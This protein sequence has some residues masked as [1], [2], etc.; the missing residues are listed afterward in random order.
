MGDSQ[1]D[2]TIT[3]IVYSSYQNINPFSD[4]NN[5]TY[6]LYGEVVPGE[7]VTYQCTGTKI[8]PN[9][10][11]SS[12]PTLESMNKLMT[13]VILGTNCISISENAFEGCGALSYVTIGNSVTSIGEGAFS[14]TNLST[15]TIPDSV[16]SIGEDAF[17]GCF[18]LQTVYIADNQLGIPSPA[19]NVSF[20]GATVTTELPTI[21]VGG[22]YKITSAGVNRKTGIAVTATATYSATASGDTLKSAFESLG[23]CANID[24]IQGNVFDFSRYNRN[25]KHIIEFD[26]R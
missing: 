2:P 26:I 7:S 6:F 24:F 5:N 21:T 17:Y 10:N 18:N 4:V 25:A 15:V 9:F 23:Y 8:I 11:F 1:Y 22:T 3:Y 12:D 19:T 13:T 20:F 14:G 16:T